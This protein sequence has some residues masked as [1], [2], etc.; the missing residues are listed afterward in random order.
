[1]LLYCAYIKYMYVAI[2]NL[3]E[4]KAALDYFSEWNNLGLKL[5]LHP[6]LLKR[7]SKDKQEVDE[8]LEA[9][10]RNWLKMKCMDS[11]KQPTWNQL[12]AAVKQLDPA[13]ANEIEKKHLI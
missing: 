1:M 11:R 13:L 12:V 3:E 9:V 8:R 6:D 10:L 5:G 2:K 7:I 4:V